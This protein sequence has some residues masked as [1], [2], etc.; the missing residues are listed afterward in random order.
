[1]MTQGVMTQAV[2]LFGNATGSVTS[3]G[4]QTG[5]SFELMFHTDIKTEQNTTGGTGNSEIK[6]TSQ[7]NAYKEN[8][9]ISDE[10]GE[11]TRQT[12]ETSKSSDRSED[13]KAVNEAQGQ[14]KDV[15][16]ESK[17]KTDSTKKTS[18]S[19]ID[20]KAME[21]IAAMLQSIKQTIL[22]VLNLS[23]EELNNLMTEQGLS[24]E[25]LLQ[26]DNLQQLVLADSG[27]TDILAVLTDEKLG[28]TMKQLI[29][30]VEDIKANADIGLTMEQVKSI[31]SSLKHEKEEPVVIA[32]DTQVEKVVNNH[33]GQEQSVVE[34]GK[35]DKEDTTSSAKRS[36]GQK[37]IGIEVIK[38]DDTK[39]SA[40][41][42]QADLQNDDNQDLKATEQFEMF[43][44][45][46][47]K[48]STSTQVD[49]DGNMM[50]VEQLRDIAHQIIEKIKVS[51][52]P[53]QTSMELQLNPEHLGKVNF[54]VQSKNGVMTAQ[55]VVQNDISKEAIES[56]LHSLKETLD[57]QG[58][59]V[60]AIEVTVASYSF[61][62]NGNE[63]T[64]TQ[65]EAKKSSSRGKITMEDALTMTEDLEEQEQTADVTGFR[66]SRI[67]YTA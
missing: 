26:P 12:S 14:K 32:A 43:L 22:E 7:Q 55:F 4:K 17:V 18:E 65:E 63:H 50:K 34:P 8:R 16:N 60:E 53:E 57:Q 45:N 6:K 54:A 64:G 28:D 13:T 67:D 21:K 62:Q 3:K 37:E 44:N 33:I 40:S 24:M 2:N 36:E 23:Q 51:I 25:D 5:N 42:S 30:S 10:A 49:F 29:Q 48:A 41:Q 9:K 56:Q 31:L 66:G 20:D 35:L 61:E 27:Q 1:M 47:T 52:Q 58:I 19:V 11:S 38:A 15:T 59:K 46:L 39:E